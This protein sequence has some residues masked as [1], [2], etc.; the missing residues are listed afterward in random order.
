MF[1]LIIAVV[2]VFINNEWVAI[3]TTYDA[4]FKASKTKVSMIKEKNEYNNLKVY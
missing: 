2:Q 1:Q 4:A 3:D